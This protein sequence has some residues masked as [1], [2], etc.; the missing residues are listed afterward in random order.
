MRPLP[1]EWPHE[2]HKVATKPRVVYDSGLVIGPAK[3]V[4]LLLARV[5]IRFGFV[6][7]R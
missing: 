1:R 7:Y 3:P 2:H 4:L 5:H 6:P